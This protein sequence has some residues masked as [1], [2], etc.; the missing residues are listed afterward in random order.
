[1]C[2]SGW[3]KGKPK[4]RTIFGL[5]IPNL[6]NSPM[7]SR[8]CAEHVKVPGCAM[9]GLFLAGVSKRKFEINR[10][11]AGCHVSKLDACIASTEPPF[12]T[13]RGSI[14]GQH[15]LRVVGKWM[16]LCGPCDLWD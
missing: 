8:V 15:P 11:F 3:F 6:T 9:M 12:E 5:L 1:M 10:R 13:V 14:V 7:L 4:R 2:F 16:P